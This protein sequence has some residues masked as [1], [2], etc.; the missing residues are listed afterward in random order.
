MLLPALNIRRVPIMLLHTSLAFI[1]CVSLTLSPCFAAFSYGVTPIRG[2]NLGGWLILEKWITPSL[3]SDL[4]SSVVD[5]Y[6]FCKYLGPANATARL[7]KHWNTWV[8]EADIV[9]LKNAGINHLRIPFG[10]WAFEIPPG[11]PW[12]NGSW[13][14]AMKA[15]GWAKKY[16]LQVMIDLHGL[17]GSQVTATSLL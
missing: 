5:E 13:T 1:V 16:G 9:S 7:T 4:P 3:F 11:E 15:I 12:V 14:Y 6:T 17:P 10:Y 2:V 8:T